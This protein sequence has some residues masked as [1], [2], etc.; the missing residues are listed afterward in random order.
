MTLFAEFETISGVDLPEMTLKGGTV[1]L[2]LYHGHLPGFQKTHN[3]VCTVIKRSSLTGQRLASSHIL[4]NKSNLILE[5]ISI[6]A[7]PSLRAL[8]AIRVTSDTCC[9]MRYKSHLR[10]LLLY[11]L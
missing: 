11:A 1:T 4:S 7:P 2:Y 6:Y 3:N 10:H 5:A 9:S 8:C